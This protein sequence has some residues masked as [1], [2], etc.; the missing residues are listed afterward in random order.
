MRRLAN[1]V[2]LEPTL[3]FGAIAHRVAS[4]SLGILYEN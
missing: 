4:D 3:L 2:G 1:A